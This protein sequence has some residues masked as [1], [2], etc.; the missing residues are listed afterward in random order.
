MQSH[1]RIVSHA[2]PEAR[3]DEWKD[4]ATDFR[5]LVDCGHYLESP[6]F[7]AEKLRSRAFRALAQTLTGERRPAPDSA[8]PKLRHEDRGRRLRQPRPALGEAASRRL[9]NLARSIEKAIPSDPGRERFL[10]DERP[11]SC[12]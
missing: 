4:A 8:L 12:S 10:Q 7:E 1:P 2:C 3:E 5:T 9:R 6:F 11:T